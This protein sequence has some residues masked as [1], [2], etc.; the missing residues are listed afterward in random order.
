MHK[1]VFVSL[2]DLEIRNIG[3][4]HFWLECDFLWYD[5]YLQIEKHLI[6]EISITNN[7]KK[8]ICQYTTQMY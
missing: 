1:T 6:L 5:P 2:W 3:K 7:E 4:A 8:V